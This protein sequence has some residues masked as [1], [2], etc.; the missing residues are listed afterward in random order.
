MGRYGPEPCAVRT[1]F[2][3]G[4]VVGGVLAPQARHVCTKHYFCGECTCNVLF[5]PPLEMDP[6][7]SKHF[8]QNSCV[9]PLLSAKIAQASTIQ[10]APTSY[11]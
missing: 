2:R 11:L 4:P 8:G 9:K 5:L 6:K 1:G 3:A 7:K 10:L